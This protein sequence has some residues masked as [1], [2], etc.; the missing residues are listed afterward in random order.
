MSIR[1]D[2]WSDFVCPFCFAVS[3][4]LKE[5]QNTHDVDV[6]WHA[7]ELRPQGSPPISPEYLSHIRATQPRLAQIIRE[8]FG[9]EVKFG[10]VDTNSR[11]ALIADK[12]AESQGA[13]TGAAFHAAVNTA[14]WLEGCNIEDVSVLKQ[15]AA[16]VGLDENAL[17]DALGDPRYE[18]EVDADIE[19]RAPTDSAVCPR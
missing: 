9:V 13:E 19:Q 5:L 2:V 17:I 18:A 6:H 1:I 3:L 11:A 8:Q 15:I 10:P 4:S 12:Y 7:F 16:E 14:Y